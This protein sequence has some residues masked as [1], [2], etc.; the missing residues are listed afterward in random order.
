MPV[1]PADAA[2]VNLFFTGSSAPTGMQVTF[3]VDI[4][5]YSADPTSAAIDVGDALGASNLDSLT[6][7]DCDLTKILVKF[8]PSSTG[9]SGEF[10]FSGEGTA[11]VGMA[12]NTAILVQKVTDAGGRA[13]RGRLYW[14]AAVETDINSAGTYA[15]TPLGVLQTAFNTFRT[16]LIASDLSPI[17]LHGENSPLESPTLITSFTVSSTVATQRRR[18]RR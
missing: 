7:N 9:P 8:G 15:A 4:Q 2:Q 16:Q 13:G 18:L 1:I 12:P 5:G 14:P 6:V 17:L 3:G 11:G 10:A